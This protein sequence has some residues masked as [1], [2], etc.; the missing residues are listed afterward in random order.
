VDVGE[1]TLRSG[2]YYAWSGRKKV[3]R[4]IFVCKPGRSRPIVID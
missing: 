1:L 4:K 2:T 3:G